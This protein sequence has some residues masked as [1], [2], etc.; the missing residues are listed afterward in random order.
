[1]IYNALWPYENVC[2]EDSSETN[3]GYR[4]ARLAKERC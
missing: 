4:R 1:L 3:N 2:S